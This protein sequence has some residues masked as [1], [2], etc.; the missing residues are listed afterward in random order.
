MLELYILGHPTP[1]ALKGSCNINIIPTSY[2][3]AVSRVTC[4]L[5]RVQQHRMRKLLAWSQVKAK[6]RKF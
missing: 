6:Q 5:T 4:F 3:E 1:Q 2:G